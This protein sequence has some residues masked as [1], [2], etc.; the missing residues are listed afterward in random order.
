MATVPT[1]PTMGIG[2]IL[3]AADMAAIKAYLDFYVLHQGGLFQAHQA[4]VQSIP[5]STDTA[6]TFTSQEID[7]DNGH[8]TITNTSRY[9]FQ[10]TGWCLLSGAYHSVSGTTDYGAFLRFNGTT[11]LGYTREPQPSSGDAY[12]PV[13]PIVQGVNPGDYVEICARQVTAG[14]LFTSLANSGSVLNIV[15]LRSL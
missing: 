11:K 15:Y 8:S 13:G 7:I 2:H 4:V 1:W 14:A 12:N 6:L 10:T 9:T 3:T 5:A